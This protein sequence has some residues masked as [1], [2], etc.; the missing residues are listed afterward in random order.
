MKTVRN[1]ALGLAAAGA[2]VLGVN[3]GAQD[4]KKPE[5]QAKPEARHE[6]GQHRG[7][8]MSQHGEMQKHM[9]EMRGQRMGQ[10]G[11]H[12]CP[13]EAKRTPDRPGELGEH[14]HS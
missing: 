13:E 11:K 7:H 4:A 5:A 2:L 8:G 14:D 6:R 1:V 3:A 10:G 12:A 9:Q